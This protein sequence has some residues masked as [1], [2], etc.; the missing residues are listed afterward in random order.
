MKF[1]NKDRIE[2]LFLGLLTFIIKPFG[3]RFISIPAKGL[4]FIFYY[5]FPVRKAVILENLRIAFPEK[6]DREIK[7]ICYSNYY[8]FLYT[9]LE[10]LSIDR[11]SPQKILSRVQFSNKD[12]IEKKI[13]N[14][15]GAVMLTAHFGN[16][17]LVAIAFGILLNIELNVIAKPQRNPYVTKWLNDLRE[18]FGNKVVPLGIS[19]RQI[20]QILKER[21]PLGVVGD[22]RGPK[23]GLRVKFFD[24]D[25]AVFQ[26]SVE[27]AAKTNTPIFAAIFVRGKDGVYRGEFI[28]LEY[29]DLQVDFEEKVKI[30]MQNY[31]NILE[32][33]VRLHPEQWFWMHKIWKY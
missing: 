6:D 22:Q 33:Y 1:I 26:G 13:R 12:E 31:M 2:F 7:K 20:Y 8:S 24:R 32:R 5:L 9:L 4:T 11:L 14:N 19:I 18:S 3:I 30:L 15:E 21:K 29:H 17:E 27:L 16:W 23:E 28:P 25:T 10:I